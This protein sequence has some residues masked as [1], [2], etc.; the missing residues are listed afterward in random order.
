M[1]SDGAYGDGDMDG[2][3]GVDSDNV[4]DGNNEAL[5]V[6]AKD[7]DQSEVVGLGQRCVIVYFLF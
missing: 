7:T 4:V 5:F 2:E 3:Q 6:E 1:S